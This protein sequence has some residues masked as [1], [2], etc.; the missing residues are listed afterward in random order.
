MISITEEAEQEKIRYIDL[1]KLGFE[2]EYYD[3]KTHYE[4][5]G[6]DASF[7][8]YE[9]NKRTRIEWE[10][11][12]RKCRIYTFDSEGMIKLEYPIKDLATVQGLVSLYKK[13]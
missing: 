10:P 8:M 5:Y 6:W 1:I 12:T 7:V 13:Y 9:L 4:M 2:V 3:D 11:T